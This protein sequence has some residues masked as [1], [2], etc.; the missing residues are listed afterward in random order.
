VEK[1]LAYAR[2]NKN[3]TVLGKKVER[4]EAVRGESE[5]LFLAPFQRGATCGV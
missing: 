5:L 2:I 1:R 4:S 3:G